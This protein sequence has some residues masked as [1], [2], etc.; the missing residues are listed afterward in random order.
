MECAVDIPSGEDEAHE[1]DDL[2]AK[3]GNE[4]PHKKNKKHRK[5]KSKK[6][7]RRRK[8]E[9]ESSSG[10]SGAESD[11][12]PPPPPRP[13]RTTRASARL[14][15]AVGAGDHA[16]MK[17]EGKRDAVTE[18]V[19]HVEGDTK[20][21][22]HK[23]HAAKKKK[24]KRKKDEKQER[25]SPSRSPSES[26]SA[27]GSESEGHGGKGSGDGKYY[28][29]GASDLQA[30]VSKLG[31]KSKRGEEKGVPIITQKPELLGV[32]KEEI[33]D[34]DV[35]SSGVKSSNTNG[36]EKDMGSPPAG[37]D[38]I[39]QTVKV[40][41]ESSHGDGAFSHAQELPD[42]IPKQE[43][44]TSRDDPGIFTLRDLGQVTHRH[45]VPVDSSL[46]IKQQWQRQNGQEFIPGHLQMIKGL[47][48]LK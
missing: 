21:K 36:S 26:S 30:S 14:A 37:Q 25:K 34:T 18:H 20:S 7:K 45:P 32:K 12:E 28:P 10:E 19:D 1:K 9:K 17:E 27:S 5:H 3:E 15:A 11:V 29:A 35:P 46:V 16:G 8:G 48:L 24:K 42:I 40:K 38:D 44:A 33:S 39:T 4:L 47:P 22:K 43:G 6:K 41:T 31:S 23:R 2:N 13:V